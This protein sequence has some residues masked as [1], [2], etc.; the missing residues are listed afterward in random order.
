MRERIITLVATAAMSALSLPAVA[1]TPADLREV[2][3]ARASSGE[4][5]LKSHGYHH[6]KS[7]RGSDRVWSNWWNPS[8]DTCL[9]VVTRNGRYDS[10]V[11]APA[12]DCNQKA[13]GHHGEHDDD[14][15]AGAI[16]AV[17]A[18]AIIGAIA[19]A[20]GSH[21]HDDGNHYS[22]DREDAQY[23]R[24]FRDG[25]YHKSYHNYDRSDAYSRGF[26][27]GAEQREH[28]TS[29]RHHHDDRYAGYRHSIEVSDIIG[30]KAS[31]SDN[32]M[33][34]RGFKQVDRQKVGSTHY[35]IWYSPDTHQCLQMTIAD[36]RVRDI[37]NI[38]RHRDCY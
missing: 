25:L 24:G 14:N 17:G 5:Q 26:E 7:Q 1:G 10:I 21:H 32:K 12:F 16:A 13:G 19:L 20:H 30:T 23:E 33:R 31:K 34:D 15:N 38:G 22:D 37:S 4:S 28:E 35:N 3:G 27:A 9:S 2:L 36:G 8:R 11:T 6:I 18:A 29:H